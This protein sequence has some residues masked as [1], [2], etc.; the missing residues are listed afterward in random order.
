LLVVLLWTIDRRQG[1][2][3]RVRVPAANAIRRLSAADLANIAGRLGIGLPCAA[4]VSLLAAPLYSN[5]SD[6]DR[7]GDHWRKRGRDK[8]HG[9][10]RHL[11]SLSYDLAET[12]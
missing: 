4:A 5:A 11:A 6:K 9:F 3:R 2:D 10:A 12:A 8:E 7:G 1:I